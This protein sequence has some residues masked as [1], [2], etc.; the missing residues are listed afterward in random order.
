M[1]TPLSAQIALGVLS[2]AQASCAAMIRTARD[3]V[4][5]VGEMSASKSGGLVAL[6]KRNP[7][8]G[9]RDCHRLMTNQCRLA[10]PLQQHYLDL[11]DGAPQIPFLRVRDWMQMMLDHNSSHILC[12]LI[13]PDAKRESAIWKAF[14]NNWERQE[15]NHPVFARARAGE[16]ELERCVPLLVHGD[17]GRSKKRLPFLVVNVHS[18]LGRGIDVGL[19]SAAR[20]RYL[21]MLPN[22]TGH[23]Y[24]N[25]FL[26]AALPKSA[27]TGRNSYVF[28]VLLE[29]VAAELCHT[30][31]VGV[32]DRSGKQWWALCLGVVGD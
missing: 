31:N 23:S 16:V 29:T 26:V 20:K 22:F 9:E 15:P 1:Y 11:K 3:F 25:R 5:D 13:R 14:W 21:K 4:A 18:I 24:T 12:G 2:L 27:Y 7:K 17:E 28:D 19:R 32:K 10:L 6:S 8:N 30:A